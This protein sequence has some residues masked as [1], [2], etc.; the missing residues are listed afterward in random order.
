MINI[1]LLHV[2]STISDFEV[3]VGII[4]KFQMEM[5]RFEY[6][7]TSYGG[8]VDFMIVKGPPSSISKSRYAALISFIPSSN[9][10]D[11]SFE[12]NFYLVGPSLCLR[13]QMRSNIFQQ[14][15][16]KP[17]KMGLKKQYLRLP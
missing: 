4:P 10:H 14:T 3:D 1:I 5:T 11:S 7:T 2:V 15:F 6:A 8:L 16:T 17:R 12:Q 9:F 13:T